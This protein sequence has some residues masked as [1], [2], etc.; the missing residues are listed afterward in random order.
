MR[1]RTYSCHFYL[2]LRL[3]VAAF[4]YMAATSTCLAQTPPTA[5]TIAF[6]TITDFGEG[7]GQYPSALAQGTDGNFYGATYYGPRSTDGLYGFGFYLTPAGSV[8]LLDY[9]CTTNYCEGSKASAG[10]TLA[11]DGNFYGTTAYG[12]TGKYR[13]VN[14]AG[15]VYRANSQKGLTTVHSFC[16]QPACQDGDDP[17]APVTLGSD[18]N[19]YG[20]TTVGG[21]HNA[22]IAYILTLTGKFNTLH[23]FCAEANCADGGNPGSLIQ[24]TDGN[25]Y[26]VASGGTGAYCIQAGDCGMIFKMTPNGV[27]TALYN[28]CSQINCADG[29]GPRVVMQAADGNLYGLTGNGG[30]FATNNLTG[31]G[32]IFKLTLQ[33]Q[34]TTLYSFCAVDGCQYGTVASSLIQATDG[35]FYGVIDDGEGAKCYFANGCGTIFEL[36]STGVYSTLYT[37]CEELGEFCSDG[38]FPEGIIQA[39]DGNFYG[40][41]GRGGPSGYGTAFQLST[42]L[43]P[44]VQTVT[45]SGAPG[46]SVIILGNN[47]TGSTKV[48]FNGVAASFDVV[49]N[50]EI[51]ATV[52]KSAT[53]GA[54]VVTTST[55]PLTSNLNFRIN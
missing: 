45:T 43:A 35:N 24:A 34:I 28:F 50:T 41:T 55:G 54:V 19:L 10:L 8:T 1:C 4:L 46:A 9:S 53:T 26:G 27:T 44:F 23:S 20:T 32:T 47:L 6:T 51:T 42:G 38:I 12:G 17:Y 30:A 36:T 40:T 3:L 49:S 14:H 7:D 25:F 2:F 18:G 13:N 11:G 22:G 5:P 52:P 33:G 31:S 21:L 16:N 39:T 29:F 48:T 15:T 37:F